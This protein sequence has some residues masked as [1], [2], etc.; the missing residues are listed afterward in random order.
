MSPLARQ[1]SSRDVREAAYEVRRAVN[2]QQA[3]A[4]F[5]ALACNGER[6][7][8]AASKVLPPPLVKQ[9]SDGLPL[10]VHGHA[11]RAGQSSGVG[12][13]CALSAACTCLHAADPVRR[14]QAMER[15]AVLLR[16]GAAAAPDQ[17]HTI[18][19]RIKRGSNGSFGFALSD[20]HYADRPDCNRVTRLM[21]GG[22]ADAAGLRLLDKVV[23]IAGEPIVEGVSVMGL[24]L[25]S[26][27]ETEAWVTVQRP[28]PVASRMQ[29]V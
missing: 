16:Q 8:T 15:L 17:L 3:R 18:D 1:R 7:L 26:R 23:A 22:A 24:G 13:Q 2:Q 20:L 14:G 28:V 5:G 6:P 29:I 27:D 19:L 9:N 4:A 11:A 25:L 10:D 12:L 21:P